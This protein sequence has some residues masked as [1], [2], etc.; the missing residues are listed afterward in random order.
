MQLTQRLVNTINLVK[1]LTLCKL[2]MH[3]GFSYKPAII[4]WNITFKCNVSCNMCVVKDTEKALRIHED[5]STE[6]FKALLIKLRTWLGHFNFHVS[7]GEPM[8]RK[9][10]FELMSFADSKGIRCMLHTN[11]TLI[12]EKNIKGLLDSGI[13]DIRIA[14]QGLEKTQDKIAQKKG[15]YK[16]IINALKIIK[17]HSKDT[18]VGIHTVIQKENVEEIPLLIEEAMKY[19]PTYI[20]IIAIYQ[21][22]RTR[23]PP[24]KEMSGWYKTGLWPDPK[25]VEKTIN[26]IINYKKKGY[27]IHNTIKHLEHI[28]KF[29]K[30]PENTHFECTEALTLSI[31]PDGAGRICSVPIGNLK[32]GPKKVWNSKK[33]KRLRKALH[34]CKR[35]CGILHSND[36]FYT[37]MKRFIRMA[38]FP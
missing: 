14:L 12:N 28:K 31:F 5:L 22:D 35:S 1:A 20:S 36:S 27:P 21:R 10:F 2:Y 34:K 19:N 9:D 30:D 18:C 7:G 26:K 11:A 32:E 25:K 15:T 33:A 24:V 37:H 8:V 3:T 16:K 17:T 29:Y 38:F 6:E 13:K 4:R 23:D